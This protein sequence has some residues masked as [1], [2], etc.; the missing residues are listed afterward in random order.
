MQIKKALR[1][2]FR[3]QRR[4]LSDQQRMQKSE[5]IVRR[6]Q[7]LPEL[8]A[9]KTLLVYVSTENEVNSHGLIADA[10]RGG[11]EVL[12]P[13]MVDGAMRWSRLHRFADLDL[14]IGEPAAGKRDLQDPA[15]NA[16]VIVPGV[17]FDRTGNRLG[18]GGGD[19]DRFLASHRGVKVGIAFDVQIADDL[20]T[21]PHDVAMD[22]L[23]TESRAV[24]FEE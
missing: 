4:S 10:L 13:A 18:Q 9:A 22:Y 8:A 14:A 24:R 3:E 15:P 20:P 16:P 21:E 23:V 1:K 19:F 17:A 6:V 5:A 12:V 7:S 2:H 11:I